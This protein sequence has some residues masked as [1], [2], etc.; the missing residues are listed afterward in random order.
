M[1]KYLIGIFVEVNNMK[2]RLT[3]KKEEIYDVDVNIYCVKNS[4]KGIIIG[5]DGEMLKKILSYA[6]EDLERI[7][8]IKL[9]M[10]VFV[11]V[12]KDWLNNE[13]IV[14]RFKSE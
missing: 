10:N 1:K 7:L 9:N 13:K 2:K 6:R 3:K 14:K 8:G 5:K 12:N 11:K 4:H